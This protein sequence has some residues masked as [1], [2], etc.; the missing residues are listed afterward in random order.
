MAPRTSPAAGP[1]R[2]APL[3]VDRIMV[4][5]TGLVIPR[6]VTFEDWQETGRR[7]TA[8]SASFAWCVGDWLVFGRSRYPNRYKH[9]VEAM[10]LDYQT[11]RNYA[12]VAGCVDVSR[13]RDGL[14]F[15]HHAEVA[16]L[17]PQEQDEWLSRAAE[18]KWTRNALRRAMRGA[19]AG[20]P[21]D[22]GGLTLRIPADQESLDRWARAARRTDATVEELIA[23]VME[24]VSEAILAAEDPLEVRIVLQGILP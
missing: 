22:K 2:R 10:G 8:L 14:S 6:A 15:Q 9:A 21:A 19:P 20:Q 24:S 4:T 12:W 5:P 3:G 7:L 11:L 1:Q 17:T 16:A 13:R 23:E 18:R